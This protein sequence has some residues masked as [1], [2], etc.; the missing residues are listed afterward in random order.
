[1]SVFRDN[2][3]RRRG[4][5]ALV[6]SCTTAVLA[7]GLLLLSLRRFA[8]PPDLHGGAWLFFSLACL[9]AALSAQPWAGRS[10]PRSRAV[11]R[12]ELFALFLILIV[13]IGFRGH[14]LASAPHGVW[15]D[16]AQNT[17]E[18][19]RI[20]EDSHYRPVFV[21]DRSQIPAMTF[22]YFAVFVRF[23]GANIF[24]VRFA[25]TVASLVAILMIWLL[26]RELWSRELGLLAAGL[27]AVS[28]W[29]VS[30]SRFAVS[31]IFV[32]VFVPL[33]LFFFVRALRR[34][35]PRDAVWAGLTLGIGL[36]F[37]YA[38][39]SVPLL[40]ALI[41]AHRFLVSPS[42]RRSSPFLLMATFLAMAFAYAPMGQFAKDHEMQ[43][44]RRFKRV[45]VFKTASLGEA[46][47]LLRRPSAERDE[48]VSSIRE[49]TLRHAGMFHFEG[50]RNGR[51]NIP[52]E[53]MLDRVTGACFVLGFVMC[54]IRIRDPRYSMLLLWFGA[55]ISAGVFSLTFEAPQGARTLGL[56][57]VIAIMSALP[58]AWLGERIGGLARTF[59]EL[60]AV[61]G[62]APRTP[63]RNP[64]RARLLAMVTTKPSEHR[65][66]ENGGRRLLILTWS[67]PV[68]LISVAGVLSWHTFF[69]RQL[70]DPA[71]W[72]AWST[73]QTKIGEVVRDEGR[74]AEVYVPA[75]FL[76]GPTQTLLL[77][78]PIVAKRFD[79]SHDL[80]LAATG[81]RALVFFQGRD[82][83]TMER[84]RRSYPDA[85]LEAFG[86]VRRDG[87][88]GTV[89]LWMARIPESDIEETH[90]WITTFWKNE[91]VQDSERIV[92]ATWDWR[93]SDV[94]PAFLASIEGAL[95]VP[96]SGTY[97]L[98]VE[99]HAPVS[100]SIDGE[101][102]WDAGVLEQLE[103]AQGMHAISLDFQ[104]DGRADRSRLLWTGPGFPEL[105]PIG[106]EQMFVPEAGVGG[107]LGQYFPGVG[108][109]GEPELEQI[110]SRVAFHYHLP[111][112]KRPFSVKWTG[113]LF[114]PSRGTYVFSARAINEVSLAIDGRQ[115]FPVA[116]QQ[117]ARSEPI[118]LGVGWHALD[119]CF[120]TWS[121][122]SQIF[123]A[124]QTPG[125]VSKWIPSE[126]LRPPGPR[127]R[128]L[129]LSDPPPR[130]VLAEALDSSHVAAGGSGVVDVFGDPAGPRWIDTS[131]RGGAR[132][133]SG[134]AG[135]F[136]LLDPNARSLTAFAGDS[137]P[138][139]VW[140]KE[141]FIAPSDVETGPDGRVFVLDAGGSI[142][143]FGRDG[144]RQGSI[145]LHE[146]GVFHPR[147]LALTPG[148][149]FVIA[150][151]GR[152]RVLIVGA[153]GDVRRT[154]GRPGRNLGQ[155][156]EPMD[157]VIDGDGG[158]VVV[159]NGNRRLQHFAADGTTTILV[160][161]P[162]IGVGLRAPRLTR[163][164]SGVIWATGGS[165]GVLWR[166]TNGLP[167]TAREWPIGVFS[168]GI[169]S[170]A[171]GGLLLLE[172]ESG[173]VLV[174]PPE[175][176]QGAGSSPPTQQER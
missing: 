75:A 50:D 71:S 58:L 5:P 148:G 28:R 84:I 127:N 173:R 119:V 3:F 86:S 54:L 103:L 101:E 21:A 32:T 73:V 109:E 6:A 59:P 120:S 60:S 31:N 46:L 81:R 69:H 136:F 174:F 39:V 159:D 130:G 135:M 41:F 72:A 76:G 78:H 121:N 138:G 49:S 143:I 115:V 92:A 80:P 24:A 33:I 149:E 126:V 63:G 96:E 77:G 51:H 19:V 139:I 106:V 117:N 155:L 140:E 131:L 100:L 67:I 169:D 176:L 108:C 168:S 141:G 167:P 64:I 128:R 30:F 23:L 125:G 91:E 48:V 79:P 156:V 70:W 89:V 166:I 153:A 172:R 93:S 105:Q 164:L 47:D 40:L 118:G 142:E 154:I 151:T 26:G 34:E 9:L 36:Q 145:D 110:D 112:L 17:L 111:P 44:Q 7:L 83:G 134:R 97:R 144:G 87:S 43:F 20:L 8:G 65:G 62:G 35:S 53:P 61:A 123:L 16:E 170:M 146:A 107:L 68:L 102:V 57:S 157:V 27:L 147:G 116:A 94:E 82:S 10:V 85:D 56:T 133:A 22:Y 42:T 95:R 55:M 14:R 12:W 104:V 171:D 18:A 52:G 45:S 122:H 160:Q 150:D 11:K 66:S 74:D 25:T 98:R 163:D 175:S 37:Y 88:R 158:V 29:H 129:D 15:A 38:M 90:G 124:W 152:G 1:M 137:E 114:A 165:K 161:D 13:G 2:A 4:S 132:I 99:G 162:A 113:S